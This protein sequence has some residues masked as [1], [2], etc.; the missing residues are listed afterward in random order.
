MKRLHALLLAM[1]LATAGLWSAS[2]QAGSTTLLLV[3]S[4]LA[5]DTDTA[6]LWQYEGGTIQN[7]AGT[8]TVGHYILTRRVT[9]AG[10]SADNTA[11]VTTSLFFAT[12]SGNTPDVITLEGAWSFTS[13]GFL[14]SVSAASNKYHWAIGAD[15]SSTIPASGTQKLVIQWLASTGLKIP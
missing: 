14:G 6:G 9:T 15:A 13:G 12:S 10:T 1:A 5:N 2:A 4:T 11:G 7:S 8:A 3:R